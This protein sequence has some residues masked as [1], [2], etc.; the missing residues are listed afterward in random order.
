[1]TPMNHENM[2]IDPHIFEKSGR[3]TD[4]HTDGHGNLYR[5]GCLL[6]SSVDSCYVS[7]YAG[8]DEHVH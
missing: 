2:E 3:Q 4:T 1:M 8:Y 5:I 6:L 7:Y